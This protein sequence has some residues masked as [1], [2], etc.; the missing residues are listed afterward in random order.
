MWAGG[1]HL[2][3]RAGAWRFDP[4]VLFD[5]R[6]SIL[7]EHFSPGSPQQSAKRGG[8]GSTGRRR[9]GAQP[10]GHLQQAMWWWWWGRGGE[11]AHGMRRKLGSAQAAG[12]AAAAVAAAQ[13]KDTGVEVMP[14]TNAGNDEPFVL[15]THRRRCP[16]GRR[17]RAAS[18]PPQG[19]APSPL[20]RRR[21]PRRLPDR[22]PRRWKGDR[23]GRRT[24]ASRPRRHL[25]AR[26][27]PRLPE[28]L[29][30]PLLS[31]ARQRRCLRHEGSEKTRQR[32]CLRH[33]GSGNARQR[34]CLRH[35]SSRTHE[36][37]AVSS[38]NKANAVC[39]HR[40][41]TRQRGRP[42]RSPSPGSSGRTRTGTTR[43]R[44]R[45]RR[46][47]RLLLLLLLLLILFT[48]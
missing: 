30:P 47:R 48:V 37:K 13:M 35:E 8:R 34:Q 6:A 23:S 44:R 40:S 2:L 38:R 18:A 42:A 28:L 31:A 7:T 41:G 46:R 12:G 15:C 17:H 39:Y 33:E 36:A 11:A 25:L 4:A 22:L 5:S 29:P 10:G 20:R 9:R 32:R 45:R 26:R 3:R 14:R 19:P 24:E 27:L 43:R 1:P 16:A 21:W